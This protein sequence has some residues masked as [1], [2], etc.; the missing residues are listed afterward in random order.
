MIGRRLLLLGGVAALAG[1]TIGENVQW[2]PW[3][4]PSPLPVTVP[5]DVAGRIA[6]TDALAGHLLANASA[7]K[8]TGRR[9]TTLEW[10]RKATAEHLQVVTSGDPARRQQATAV[11][12]ST[13]SPTQRTASGT[14]SALTSEL[15][16]LQSSHRDS[17]RSASGPAALLWASLAAFSATMTAVLPSGSGA[18]G[19]DGTDLTPDLT[20]TGADRALQLAAQAAYSY[21]MALAATGLGTADTAALR[22]RLGQWRT[23]RAAILTASPKIDAGTPPVAYDIRPARNRSAARQLAAHT[24]TMALPLLGAWLAGTSSAAERRLGVDALIAS[25]TAL[26]SFGGTVL[27][28]PG[29][30]G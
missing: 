4:A 5:D 23:L 30:P 17:A 3:T 28:W 8:L 11:P 1:C 2:L 14:Q 27:R 13:P 7:W 16:A 29:W 26:T 24:E 25:N 12:S 22:V 20:G 21:E 6:R 18:L 10:F 9:V 15:S 19:D